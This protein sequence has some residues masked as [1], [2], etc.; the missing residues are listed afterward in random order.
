MSRMK[1]KIIILIVGL[2]ALMSSAQEYTEINNR[3]NEIYKEKNVQ[4]TGRITDEKYIRRAYLQIAGRIPTIKEYDEF[5]S[6]KSA[7]KRHELVDK[8][9]ASEDF[10][11]HW[12]NYWADILRTEDRFNVNYMVGEPYID[13]I[14]SSIRENKPYDVF[15][16]EIITATGTVYESPAT[17]YFWKD[18]GMPLDNLAGTSEIFFGTNI[19]CAQCH[20][21]PFNDWT[22]M[23]YFRFAAFFVQNQEFAGTKEEIENINKLRDYVIETRKKYES[24]SSS[25]SP[26]A[27]PDEQ[28]KKIIARGTE[29]NVTQ[30]LRASNMAIETN[31]DRKM[32][33]PHD[34][35]YEDG[36]PNQNVTPAFLFGQKEVTTPED[37]RKDFANWAVSKENPYFTRNIVNRYWNAIFGVPIISPIEEISTTTNISDESLISLLEKIF[38]DQ[39]YDS[40]KFLATLYKT[41][42]FERFSYVEE[43]LDGYNFQGPLLRRLSAEQVWDSL[44]TLSVDDVN[45]FKST[46]STEYN[47]LMNVD[48]SKVT[49]EDSIKM[50]ET[51]NKIRGTKYET[52]QKSNGLV[53]IRASEITI[54]NATTNILRELGQSER[55]LIQDSTRE[56]SVTQSIMFMNG[57]ISSITTDPNSALIKSVQG[58][59]AKDI[60]DIAFK[61]IL[62]RLPSIQERDLF[63][64]Y[65]KED[66]IWALTNSHEFKFN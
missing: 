15:V 66:L 39:N 14:K 36:E 18:R 56:G 62:Q 13:W 27:E 17:G 63:I 29:N 4:P 61:S 9:I 64:Q 11:S 57:P 34:Y 8:L 43:N 53:L 65:P 33:L 16:K 40:K 3:L 1:T 6:N 60:I 28:I 2:F 31:K 35:K 23:D 24:E 41:N 46:Y 12:F 42:L 59:E 38:K 44:L 7:N 58:K 26:A 50:V 45:Y 48:A 20:D 19:S 52:A 51:Y 10:T 22:Q 30:I 37:Y 5:I 21:D 54:P 55:I 49:I 32:K 47:I 25:E